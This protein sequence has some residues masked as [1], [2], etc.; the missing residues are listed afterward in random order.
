MFQLTAIEFANQIY[1]MH[2]A[3]STKKLSFFV[4]KSSEKQPKIDYFVILNE[5]LY[6]NDK[7]NS[8]VSHVGNSNCN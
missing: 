7:T 3:N 1:F 6:W 4:Y 5:K 2:T 8:K